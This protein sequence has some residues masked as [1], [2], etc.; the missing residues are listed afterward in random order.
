MRG[1]SRQSEQIVQSPSGLAL[2]TFR[3]GVSTVSLGNMLQCLT[4]LIMNNF[5]LMSNLNLPFCKL[6]TVPLC[7]TA[8][9]P[10]KESLTYRPPLIT[11][12]LLRG[13][14]GACSSLGSRAPTFSAFLHRGDSPDSRSMM[15]AKQ[16]VK[17]QKAVSP[18]R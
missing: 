5:F 4:T 9:H 18:M 7:P 1:C 15:H 14:C 12:R 3:D 17:C 13:L 6:K 8:T 16:Q 11:V 10:N 2:N